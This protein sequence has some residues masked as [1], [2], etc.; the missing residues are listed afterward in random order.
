[1]KRPKRYMGNIKK[2]RAKFPKEL[3]KIVLYKPAEDDLA[4]K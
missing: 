4:S 2:V 3:K 1:V